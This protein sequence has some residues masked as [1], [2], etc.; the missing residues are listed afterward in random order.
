MVVILKKKVKK[1]IKIVAKAVKKGVKKTIKIVTDSDSG[2]DSDSDREIKLKPKKRSVLKKVALATTGLAAL[3]GAGALGYH[4][5]K[6]KAQTSTPVPVSSPA[7]LDAPIVLE[8]PVVV[9]DAPPPKPPRPV[10]IEAVASATPEEVEIL[11]RVRDELRKSGD[12]PLEFIRGMST[13]NIRLGC[14]NIKA[15]D[16]WLNEQ[17]KGEIKTCKANKFKDLNISEA[18]LKQAEMSLHC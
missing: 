10:P 1:P 6:N 2:E 13:T 18:V 3:I 5:Y 16:Q 9:L 14:Q 15:F 11:K 17:C 4:L 12:I 8:A 7:V